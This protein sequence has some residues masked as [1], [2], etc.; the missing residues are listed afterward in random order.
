MQLSDGIG[1]LVT[2]SLNLVFCGTPDFAVPSLKKLVEADFPVRLVVPQPARP[3]DR[4]LE[5]AVS[6][7]KQRALDLGLPVIQPDKIKANEEFRSQLAAIKPDALIV[8]G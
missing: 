3:K 8:V 6:P 4:G 2:Q 1:P 7:V 5:P